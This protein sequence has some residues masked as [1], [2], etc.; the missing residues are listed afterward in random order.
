MFINFCNN[1]DLSCIIIYQTLFKL[2][3]QQKWYWS[4]LQIFFKIYYLN[5]F[6]EMMI[7]IQH[8]WFLQTILHTGKVPETSSG[9]C[10]SKVDSP[11]NTSYISWNII[12]HQ[13][14]YIYINV[15]CLNMQ[16]LVEQF[17]KGVEA[18]L[19]RELYYWH[20]Y[21]VS[22]FILYLLCHI[23]ETIV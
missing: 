22:Y 3:C 12:Y 7:H 5:S 20:G 4:T 10:S 14:I 21:Y 6:G 9:F 1:W 23:Y 15:R 8:L 18:S 17:L 16:K 2:D 11:G 19:K 13:I